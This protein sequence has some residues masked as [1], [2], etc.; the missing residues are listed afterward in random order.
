MTNRERNLEFHRKQAAS[1]LENLRDTF[2][3]W[4]GLKELPDGGDLIFK[5]NLINEMHRANI[6]YSELLKLVDGDERS[7]INDL[8]LV[9]NSTDI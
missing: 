7:D 9:A 6:T 2:D 1:M 5:N 8:K 3:Q 4:Q